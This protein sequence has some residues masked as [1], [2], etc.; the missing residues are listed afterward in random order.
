MRNDV[1]V[2]TTLLAVNNDF[3]PEITAMIGASIAIAISDIP[4]NGP[5]G[6]VLLGYVDGQYVL[7]PTV[8]QRAVSEM[9]VTV[10]A[11]EEKI[12]MIEAGAKEVPEDIM[13]NGI[14]FAH[15]ELK[16]IVRFIKE[17]AAEI[18]KPK[19]VYA[20]AEINHDLL[21]DVKS[22]CM[23]QVE[24]ALDTDDKDVRDARL[25]VVAEDVSAHFAEKYPDS[26]A[27]FGEAIYKTEKEI[28]RR[29]L[30]DEHRR[31]D[32]RGLEDIRPLHAEVGLL[33][34]VHGSG[35]FSR[36]QTQVL[37]IATRGAIADKQ[38][39]VSEVLSSNG[40]TSQGSV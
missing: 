2:S 38:K 40:S 1:V 19:F 6:G 23:K 31:V 32:G 33:P 11:T 37:T 24:Y 18:G 15:Q 12:V 10:A 26:E 9:A 4:W 25:A 29:W 36:G 39:L 34:R 21:E 5:I 20:S 8:A 16:K 7:N 13:L 14:I 3:P 28:V 22:Y 17:I 35:L 27:A 30:F